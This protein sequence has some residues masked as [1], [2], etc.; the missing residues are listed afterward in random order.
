MSVQYDVIVVGAGHA[1]CEAAAAAARMGART[2][3]FTHRIESIGEMSCNPAIGGIG[4]GHLVREIDALDG[5]MGRVADYAGIQF[6]VL[7]RAKGPAVWGPRAQMDRH[8]YRQGMQSEIL[9]YPNLTAIELEVVDVET[10]GGAISA[11]FTRDG[12]RFT[13][14]S[15]VLAAGT[16]MR[17]TIF[18]GEERIPA[19]RYGEAA[20]LGLSNFLEGIKF[21]LGRL[22]T[23]TPARLD[24]RSID[25]TGL[26][27]QMG[28]ECPM[29]FSYLT[30]SITRRQISCFITR[31]TKETHDIIRR[32]LFRS[33]MYSGSITGHGPRYCPSIEDKVVKFEDR[34]SHQVFLEPEGLDDHTIYPNG[35][36]TSLPAD[37]Q[38]EFM[39]SLPG[40]TSVEIIR[41]GY[42]IEYDFIDPRE[43]LPTLETKRV[44]GLFLA[45]QIIGTTGYEEAAGL[46]IVAGMN[47]AAKR[48]GGEIVLS[49][50]E[51]YLGV[52]VDD[53]ITRGVTEPY[54]MFTSRAEFRLALRA[55]NAD[56]RL[57]ALGWR[58]GVMGAGRSAIFRAKKLELDAAIELTRSL[59]ISPSRAAK[60]G[61]PVNQDG[62]IRNAFE[63]LSYPE[64]G[65]LRIASVWP[66]LALLPPEI[67]GQL[68]IEAKYAVYLERQRSDIAG[69]KK[70][71]ECL[72]PGDLDYSAMSGLSNEI[73]SRFSLVRPLTLAQA[74]RIEGVTPAS[75]SILLANVRRRSLHG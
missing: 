74:G 23:G 11:V 8:L 46:G 43:L 44:E 10:S 71:E 5:L 50:S 37:V 62:V 2:A 69:L 49:R 42:A 28:D 57:T 68:A 48:Y 7:N 26:E 63:L 35:L 33:A 67:L 51:A 17:G 70:E 6:R 60:A 24:G 45:G 12:S 4:K 21:K 54:R 1:G 53:L 27:R 22:K 32:N 47:A 3:L 73:R 39:R 41:P 40:L 52:M 56:Q 31:T 13:C 36:S 38:L 16:F 72:L 61:L 14:R 75:L 58:V 9:N 25:W 19:G 65:I 34:D 15:L 18:R 30:K 20:T 59:T 55:D 29:P 64:L 66:E